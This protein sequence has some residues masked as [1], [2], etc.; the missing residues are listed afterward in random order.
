MFSDLRNLYQDPQEIEAR[1]SSQLKTLLEGWRDGK[2]GIWDVL[3]ETGKIMDISGYGS[4]FGHVRNDDTRWLVEEVAKRNGDQAKREG[5]TVDGQ[6]TDEQKKIEA[7]REKLKPH[8]KPIFF[9]PAQTAEIAV[10]IGELIDSIKTD[11][12]NSFAAARVIVG[13]ICA[14][15]EIGLPREIWSDFHERYVENK[16]F[17]DMP[18]ERFFARLYELK[19]CEEARARAM[20]VIGSFDPE[21]E[22]AARKRLQPAI[23][24]FHADAPPL[25]DGAKLIGGISIDASGSGMIKP[26][27]YNPAYLPNAPT[28]GEDDFDPYRETVDKEH[29]RGTT[30]A[31]ITTY[32]ISFTP[33]NPEQ[34]GSLRETV[35]K[36]LETLI[37]VAPAFGIPTDNTA[38]RE[39]YRRPRFQY[40]PREGIVHTG[41]Y[42]DEGTVKLTN[43]LDLDDVFNLYYLL[44]RHIEPNASIAQ[45]LNNARYVEERGTPMCMEDIG[46]KYDPGNMSP[47]MQIGS[48]HDTPIGEAVPKIMSDA[49]QQ[50]VAGL[51]SEEQL[52]RQ[53][54]ILAGHTLTGR[55]ADP[56]GALP[57]YQ[58]LLEASKETTGVPVTYEEAYRDRVK[59]VLHIAIGIPLDSDQPFAEALRAR[60]EATKEHVREQMRDQVR[61]QEAKR[62]ADCMARERSA[63]FDIGEMLNSY[64]SYSGAVNISD[65][66]AGYSEEDIDRSEEARATALTLPCNLALRSSE[67]GYCIDRTYPGTLYTSRMIHSPWVRHELPA[68]LAPFVQ[69]SPD[70]PEQSPQRL[71]GQLTGKPSRE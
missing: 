1:R 13:T 25:E 32:N 54:F 66:L 11:N 15:P 47:D 38:E 58:L 45:A 69:P 62:D 8:I 22:D 63:N 41:L 4:P 31:R 46:E 40:Y 53:A 57:P 24:Q 28:S 14:A 60:T 68:A 19:E 49:V 30:T 18:Y 51:S 21:P 20:A 71:F 16:A 56:N 26:R 10:G 17:F 50:Y 39:A 70:R 5:F 43:R 35:R 3:Y 27:Y 2:K 44:E 64:T 59:E 67:V 37:D 65:H 29:Y 23:D 42:E 36:A 48:L 12:L 33:K 55:L 61:A 9:D 52:L 6:M 7:A 34:L